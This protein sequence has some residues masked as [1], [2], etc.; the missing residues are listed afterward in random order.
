MRKQE[1][2]DDLRSRLSALP[3]PELEE[4]LSFYEEIIND[5]ME[6]GLSEEEAA[7]FY[8]M[9]SRAADRAASYAGRRFEEEE[10]KEDSR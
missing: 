4:R 8:D 9:L 2:M 3:P 5:R 10:K 1:F 7:I 6:E